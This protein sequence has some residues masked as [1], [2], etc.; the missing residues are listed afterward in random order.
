MSQFLNT[1]VS[2]LTYPFFLRLVIGT[3]MFCGRLKKRKH[4]WLNAGICLAV[5]IAIAGIVLPFNSSN[6][7]IMILGYFVWLSAVLLWLLLCFEEPIQTLLFCSIAGYTAQQLSGTARILLHSVLQHTQ[8]SWFPYQVEN[9]VLSWLFS[10]I[11]HII[12]YLLIYFV[13]VWNLKTGD[14]NLK[15]KQLFILSVFVLLIDIVLHT[16]TVEHSRRSDDFVFTTIIYAYNILSCLLI[17]YFQFGS[18]SQKQLQEEVVFLNEL[19]A[20]QQ[21]QYQLSKETIDSINFKCHDLKHQIRKITSSAD[22]NRE[23]AKEIED[24]ISI[25]DSAVK[26]GNEALDVILTEKSLQCNEEN[27]RITCIADGTALSFMKDADIYTLFGNAIDNAIEAV[28]K[29]DDKEKRIIGL[30][31]KSDENYIVIHIYNY[32]NGELQFSEGH[33]STSKNDRENHGFGVR[34]MEKIAEK[35]SG[36]LNI[37]AEDNVFHLSITFQKQ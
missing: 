14:L 8:L 31:V 25:Y 24:V 13:L 26:T 1:I 22:I 2:A 35:Y 32:Y 28:E 23:T 7:G 37:L 34:S 17:Y 4:F 36:N 21:K 20:Q 19:R 30:K 12:I 3:L 9:A 27:I 11:P 6:T 10:Q 16:L 29:L 5:Y 33:P 18:L 15:N